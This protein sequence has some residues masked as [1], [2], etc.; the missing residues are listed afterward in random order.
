MVG[1]IVSR[2]FAEPFYEV[3]Q[4]YNS[5]IFALSDREKIEG[6]KEVCPGP[7]AGATAR[8]LACCEIATDMSVTLF[9]PQQAL[10]VMVLVCLCGRPVHEQC[11]IVA[12]VS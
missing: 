12:R 4:R 3:A 10:S 7:I 5:Q 9:M 2:I 6:A 8:T 11:R 1:F